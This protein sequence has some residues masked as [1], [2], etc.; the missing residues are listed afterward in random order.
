MEVVRYSI[1]TITKNNQIEHSKESEWAIRNVKGIL[2]KAN[3]SHL[4]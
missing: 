2:S 1:E 4:P 3:I